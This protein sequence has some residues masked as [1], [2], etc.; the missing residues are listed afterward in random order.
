ML[1]MHNSRCGNA[2]MQQLHGV[3]VEIA[4]NAHKISAHLSDRS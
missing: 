3:S 1:Q 4:G 2:A